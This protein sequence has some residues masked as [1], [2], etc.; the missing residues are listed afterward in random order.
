MELPVEFRLSRGLYLSFAR[1]VWCVVLF[2]R[3]HG[4][5]DSARNLSLSLKPRVLQGPV[6][7]A[8]PIQES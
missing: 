3:Y 1:L 2:F 4:C 7:I 8:M 5:L 6:F